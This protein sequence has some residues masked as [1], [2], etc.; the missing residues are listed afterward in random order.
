MSQ[1]EQLQQ[2]VLGHITNP[3]LTLPQKQLALAQ[4]A[5]SLVP[6]HPYG[7]E[8]ERAFDQGLLHDMFESQCPF[9][10]RYV[11]PDYAKAM[12]QGCEFLEMAPPKD[13]DEALNF[14]SILYLNVPSVT[15]YPVFLGHLDQLLEPFVDGVS[16][17]ELEKAL[18]LFWQR[19]DRTLPDSFVHANLGPQDSRVGRMILR[20]DAALGQSVPNLT[21]RYQQ[22]VTPDD[23]LRRVTDNIIACNK[24]HIANHEAIDAEFDR[25]YGVV[26]CYNALPLGG[27]SHT[28]LRLNLRRSFELCDGS[29]QDYIGTVVPRCTELVASAMAH[30]IRFLVE[31]SGFFQHHFLCKEGLVSL[32]RFTAM[33]GIYGLAELVNQMMDAL[34]ESGRYGLDRDA[35]ALGERIVAAYRRQI[36]HLEMIYCQ[37]GL[38]RFHSQSGISCDADET[39]GTRIPVG[40]E[41]DPLSHILACAPMHQY[42]DGGISDIFGLDPTIRHNPGALV[43]LVTGGFG[44]GL[45]MFTANLA[46]NDLV[47]VTGYMVKRSDIDK[48]RTEAERHNSTCLGAE[49]VDVVKILERQARVISQ[50]QHPVSLWR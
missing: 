17:A 24:P 28:L 38:M 10:P 1:I 48:F 30:R 49:A 4:L 50:E 5:E 20:V 25:G 8:V 32:D 26:S 33:F 27:G 45:K 23:L 39:A 13:L 6:R 31:E 43:R 37:G 34:G 19:L 41:P 22:G 44:M 7:E 16:D 40:S 18:T 12:V 21:F 36:D 42:F 9:K 11:L 2:A 35:T 14:L 47:R 46:D 29:E 15:G 3:N